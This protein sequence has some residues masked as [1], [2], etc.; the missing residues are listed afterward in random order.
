[1]SW[2]RFGRIKTIKALPAKSDL[3]MSVCQENEREGQTK[4]FFLKYIIVF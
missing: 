2:H 1:M 3:R 4:Y